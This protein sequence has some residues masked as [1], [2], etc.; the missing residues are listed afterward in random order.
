[1]PS[2]QDLQEME[3]PDID[4]AQLGSSMAESTDNWARS[5]GDSLMGGMRDA[6]DWVLRWATE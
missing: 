1:M 6:K 2:A 3:I 4:W 5:T